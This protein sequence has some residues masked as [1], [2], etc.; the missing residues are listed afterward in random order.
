LSLKNK[1]EV[2]LEIEI[3]DD[4]FPY[5]A[6]KN[7][8]YAASKYPPAVY[9][10]LNDDAVTPPTTAILI[11]DLSTTKA[12]RIKCPDGIDLSNLSDI[13]I[14]LPYVLKP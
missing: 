5:V 8:H 7:R 3:I 14:V 2:E 6:R 10:I 12:I 11:E 1:Q 4:L 13:V 9:A